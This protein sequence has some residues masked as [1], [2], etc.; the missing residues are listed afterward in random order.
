VVGILVVFFNLLDGLLSFWFVVV[1]VTFG[2]V[3]SFL[4]GFGFLV[5]F[6]G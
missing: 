6:F 4:A 3:I 2:L 1:V 5:F